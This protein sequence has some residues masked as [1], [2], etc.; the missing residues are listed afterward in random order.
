MRL[1]TAPLTPEDR[2]LLL[3]R[4]ARMN[5][6]NAF[7]LGCERPM[8]IAWSAVAQQAIDRS[9]YES[10]TVNS[11]ER[12]FSHDIVDRITYVSYCFD[13]L[14]ELGLEHFAIREEMNRNQPNSTGIDLSRVP[15]S[16]LAKEEKWKQ[17]LQVITAF[18]FYEVKSVCD[19]LKAWNIDLAGCPELLFL[20]KSR[21][22]FLAHPELGGVMR[23]SHRSYG[24]PYDGSP[25]QASIAGLNRSD[26]ITRS[27][28]LTSLGLDE[29]TP[30]LDEAQ[31]ATNEQLVLSRDQNHRLDPPDITRLKAFGLRDV[32]LTKALT[33]LAAVLEAQVLPR[34]RAAFEAAV[35]DFG[36]ERS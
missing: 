13:R 15:P 20:M 8:S 22:R 31:R 11:E 14:C 4:A 19:M 12:N 16:V 9:Q 24:I 33:E 10:F 30:T 18:I 3:V 34:I 25:V 32:N 35:R 29:N 36:F 26:P 7:L 28:Y 27:H 17:E 2:H 21:D 23:L 5:P 1:S 6:F